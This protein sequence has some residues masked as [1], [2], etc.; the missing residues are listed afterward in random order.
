MRGGAIWLPV[1]LVA[2]AA[3][4][5]PAQELEHHIHLGDSLTAALKHQGALL[6]YEAALA[7]DSTSYRALWKAAG[8]VID[9]AKQLDG[10]VNRRPRDSLYLLARGYA[11][12][13]VRSD[14]MGAD[15]YF[16]L[17]QAVGRLAR[18]RGG[19]ERVRFGRVI[20]QAAARAIEL[21]PGQD[22]AHHVLGAWHAEVKRLSGLTRFFAKTF[23][24]AGFLGRAQWDS[25][26]VHL[27]RAVELRPEYIY[28][29]LELAEVY[30]DRRRYDDARAQLE[31]IPA[32]PVSDV[33]DPKHQAAAAR[34]LRG[35]ESR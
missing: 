13:A 4:A 19:R 34:L 28:H 32:L 26:V 9:I 20:Y 17:A 2:V 14:S 11:E 7:E 30:L 21:N 29:R 15:G 12:A 22:G 3:R 18:T 35:L 25:A 8:A 1:L 10:D 23:L 16:M 5:A 27:E 6:H 24:G 31:R 33:L